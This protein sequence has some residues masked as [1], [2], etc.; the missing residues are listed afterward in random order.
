MMTGKQKEFVLHYL[1]NKNAT[2]AY[3]SVYGG[4]VETAANGGCRLLKKPEIKAFLQEQEALLLK[5]LRERV[6]YTKEDSFNRLCE[7]Q[8][9]ALNNEAKIEFT[10]ALKAE[11]LK[12]KLMGLYSDQSQ[13]EEK[14][15]PV[16]VI[17]RS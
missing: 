11:E 5:E 9:K 7:I 17:I 1:K 12:G 8:E 14:T 16:E 3:M 13:K 6:A 4:S 15:E 10:A 2:K